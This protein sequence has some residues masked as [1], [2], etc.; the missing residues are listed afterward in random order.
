[1]FGHLPAIHSNAA[2]LVNR[3][4]PIGIDSNGELANFMR[5]IQ[6]LRTLLQ[7]HLDAASRSDAATLKLAG[8]WLIA[9]TGQVEAIDANFWPINAKQW[10]SCEERLSSSA[11][12]FFVKISDVVRHIAS[13]EFKGDILNEW[14]RRC[15]RSLAPHVFDSLIEAGIQRLGLPFLD[16]VRVRSRHYE[17]WN[18]RLRLMHEAADLRFEAERLVD[19]D[20]L[21]DW[22]DYCPLNGDDII[23]RLTVPPGP[24]VGQI[25]LKARQMWREKPCSAEE[26]L[27]RVRTE[28]GL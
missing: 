18:L 8:G 15:S 7:H 24:K 12:E 11:K 10:A 27:K 19:A 9:S 6:A 14:A 28:L 23:N 2:F 25:L 22:S 16:P 17:D 20:L 13:D 1:M 21:S 5:D 3:A 4:R 26:L